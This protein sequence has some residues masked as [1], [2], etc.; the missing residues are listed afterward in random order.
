MRS[1]HTRPP[2]GPE[3][4]AG[5][6]G[7]IGGWALAVLDAHLKLKEPTP[8]GELLKQIPEVKIELIGASDRHP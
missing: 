1:G 7:R 2:R 4:G 6:L 5:R 3:A 8:V